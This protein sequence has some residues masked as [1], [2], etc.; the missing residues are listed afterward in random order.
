MGNIPK[1]FQ[2]S[3]LRSVLELKGVT[4]EVLTGLKVK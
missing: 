1:M 4:F 3:A 2:S